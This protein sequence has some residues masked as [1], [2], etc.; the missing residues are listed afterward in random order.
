IRHQRISHSPMETRGV[1]AS[2][3]GDGELIVYIGCQGPQVVARWLSLAFG[4]PQTRIRVISQDVGGSFGLKAQPWREEVAV[5][6]AG[7]LLG[8]PL[9]WIEDRV[10]NLI[11]ANQAREQECTLSAAFDAQGRLL[12]SRCDYALNNG[13]YPHYPDC[14]TA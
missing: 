10:E 4:L 6:A 14:N 5:I 11:S 12:A 2:K 8:R 9:K 13:A 1:V 3:Q 7:M